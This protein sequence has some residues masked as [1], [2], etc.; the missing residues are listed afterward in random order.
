MKYLLA[1]FV[2]F[3]ATAVYVLLLHG[4]P[5]LAGMLLGVVITQVV[6]DHWRAAASARRREP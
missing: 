6:A 1:V 2:A 5:F 3:A 4:V